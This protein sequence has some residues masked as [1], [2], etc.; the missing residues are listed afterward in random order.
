MS[1]NLYYCVGC[2][3][4]AS[5]YPL[6]TEEQ[7]SA[8]RL[9][10]REAGLWESCQGTPLLSGFW[11]CPRNGQVRGEWNLGIYFPRSHTAG[12]LKVC[13][14]PLPQTTAT[15]E[16]AFSFI[17]FSTGFKNHYFLLPLQAWHRTAPCY[18]SP[19]ILWYIWLLSLSSCL[20]IPLIMCFNDP[21][22]S[23]RTFWLIE[24]CACSRHP[25]SD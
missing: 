15:F 13:C 25:L 16:P 19:K 21:L 3:Q 8:S 1:W 7:R 12:F 6:S 2:H 5:P 4:F 17:A 24:L 10:S 14:D 20:V 18:H 9:E 23:A 22:V 11:L